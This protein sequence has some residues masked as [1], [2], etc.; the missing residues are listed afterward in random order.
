MVENTL[1]DKAI[2]P[3]QARRRGR[4][5]LFAVLLA[6][7]APLIASYLSYYVIKP[8]GRTNYG[9][10]ID[11]RERPIPPMASTTLAGEP[12]RLEEL[13]GKWLMV[14]VGGADCAQACQKQLH[15][16]RQWRLMQGKNMDRIQRV[17]LLTDAGAPDA[18][19]LRQVEGVDVLEGVQVLRADAATVQ[20]W[21][22]AEA[23]TG[24]ADH[25]YLIDPLGNLMMRFPKEPEP[26]RVYQDIAKLL[27][28]SAIG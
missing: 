21:L 23:G 12:R 9:T 18:A 17:W 25:I 19:A 4:W 10:L 6:C 1:Q 8:S 24:A 14:K 5:K 2:D 28:A 22:P 7:A 15:A 26:R 3:T 16:M 27:K 11:P 20:R 13:A